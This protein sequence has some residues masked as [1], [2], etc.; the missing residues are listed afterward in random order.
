MGALDRE[1]FPDSSPTQQRLDGSHVRLSLK[2]TELNL[3]AHTGLEP[4]TDDPAKSPESI[5]SPVDSEDSL[6]ASRTHIHREIV[7]KRHPVDTE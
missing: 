6:V 5:D 7:P 3:V 2:R 4:D 1:L